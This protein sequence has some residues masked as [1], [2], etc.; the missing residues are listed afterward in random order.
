MNQRGDHNLTDP[1]I[2]G[3]GKMKSDADNRQ[4]HQQSHVIDIVE[5]DQPSS[6]TRDGPMQILPSMLQTFDD[7]SCA[8]SLGRCCQHPISVSLV[9][10]IL[11]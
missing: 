11:K 2:T 9:V 5:T 4:Q 8:V 3:E 7:N 6:S 10:L 1:L